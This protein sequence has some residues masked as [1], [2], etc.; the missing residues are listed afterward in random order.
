MS[1]LH[2]IKTRFD[3]LMEEE[4]SEKIN[5]DMSYPD[6]LYICDT[7]IQEKFNIKLTESQ[8]LDYVNYNIMSYLEMEKELNLNDCFPNGIVNI[9][10]VW[11][12]RYAYEWKKNKLQQLYL[13]RDF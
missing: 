9:V 4:M 7:Y 6:L 12:F 1:N 8:C 5:D 13:N 11:R 3:M 10:N 2:R